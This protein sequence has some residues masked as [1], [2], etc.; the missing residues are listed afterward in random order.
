MIESCHGCLRDKNGEIG[1]RQGANRSQVEHLA[2]ICNAVWRRFSSSFVPSI[3]KHYTR[4]YV[5]RLVEFAGMALLLVLTLAGCASMVSSKEE[6]L[7]LG[8]NE[9]LVS[10]SFVINVEKNE[11]NES[12][13]AFLKGR[14]TANFEYGV[15]I[16]EK[17]D[18]AAADS[19]SEGLNI[20]K[21]N[22]RF[23][24][25]PEQE[26]TFLK[27]L[28]AGMYRIRQIEQLGF[29]NAHINLGIDFTVRSKQTSY[30]G[31]LTIVLPARA[32]AGSQIKIMVSDAQDETINSLRK[33]YGDTVFSNVAKDLMR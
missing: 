7:S 1:A 31:R 14:K 26:F 23:K 16:S 17:K 10:G 29:S 8:E 27:K 12:G 19:L 13:W 2:R 18:N 5:V 30:I 4:H 33:E 15:I 32:R 6:L 24:V 25:K 3:T 21:T 20:F 9:G 28:P 11:E 22:Y